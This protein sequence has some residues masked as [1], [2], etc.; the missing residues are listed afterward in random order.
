MKTVD[1]Q[2]SSQNDKPLSG[3]RM[4]HMLKY[5][6]IKA[7]H[8][9]RNVLPHV[10]TGV[11]NYFLAGMKEVG[12]M[13]G[14]TRSLT[15]PCKNDKSKFYGC[16]YCSKSN[17]EAERKALPTRTHSVAKR[18]SSDQREEGRNIPHSSIKVRIG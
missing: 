10:S 15:Q 5:V 16:K 4:I 1:T 8:A 18:P 11:S 17:G 9:H 2:R 12:A 7:L 3:T 13:R 14:I 6:N